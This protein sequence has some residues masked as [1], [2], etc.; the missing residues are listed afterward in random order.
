MRGL[1]LI[2]ALEFATF[3]LAGRNNYL[4][5][6]SDR[7][8]ATNYAELA[9]FD[10]DNCYDSLPN[11]GQAKAIAGVLVENGCYS[12]YCLFFFSI[13]QL[14]MAVLGYEQ[15]NCTGTAVNISSADGTSCFN[16][17]SYFQG[18]KYR[19]NSF[20]QTPSPRTLE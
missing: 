20:L 8:C 14:I 6:Y 2:C 16:A 15:P 11:K 5:L 12:S 13:R 1:S 4:N 18:F 19:D 3:S 7:N 17:D 10:N 9:I